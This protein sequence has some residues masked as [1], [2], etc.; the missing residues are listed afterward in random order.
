MKHEEL[1]Y[2]MLLL[3]LLLLRG[4]PSLPSHFSV[5]R[6]GREP[7]QQ[8]SAG[9]QALNPQDAQKWE[10]HRARQL[11]TRQGFALVS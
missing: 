4:A 7:G 5:R 1:V 10:K 2:R 6:D 11:Y 3:L 9:V 8:L